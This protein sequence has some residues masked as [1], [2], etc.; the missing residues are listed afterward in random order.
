MISVG[1]DPEVPLALAR[2][3]RDEARAQVATHIDPSA[4]RAAAKHAHAQS[5]EA[6]A[7][8]WYAMNAST[9]VSSHAE[10]VVSRLEK[11]VSPWLGN[12]PIASIDAPAVLE[13]LRRI[14][15][16]GAADSARRVRQYLGAIFRYAIATGRAKHDAAADLRDAIKV[17]A[18]EHYFTITD[19]PSYWRITARNRWLQRYEC[20]ARRACVSAPAICPAGR[21]ARCNVVRNRL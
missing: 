16:R 15:R 5:L 7:R 17:P 8:E 11:D 3:R 20:R 2:K 18:K 14:E 6:V 19:P 10:K 4:V 21:I 12:H 1:T 13:C 9:W